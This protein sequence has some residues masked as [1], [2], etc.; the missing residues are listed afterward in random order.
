MLMP[1]TVQIITNWKN[2]ETGIPD[3][4]TC[5]LRN[6]YVGQEACLEQLTGSKL[7]KECDKAVYCHPVYLTYVQSTSYETLGWMNYKLAR[8]NNNLRYAD[9]TILMAESEEELKSLL[10]RVK[11]ENEKAG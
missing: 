8:R 10:M 6:L 7:R 9:G 2:I 5:L 3:H 4:H 11:K 1:L